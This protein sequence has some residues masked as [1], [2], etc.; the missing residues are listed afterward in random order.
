[1]RRL[2]LFC[3]I[4]LFTI[5]PTILAQGNILFNHITIDNGLSQSSVTCI[6]QDKLGF[7]W[8]GTQDGLNR[9][10]GYNFKVFKNIPKDSTSLAENFI[11]SLYED[12]SGTLYIETQSGIFHKYYQTTRLYIKI[13]GKNRNTRLTEFE[14]SH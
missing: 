5:T 7:M 3:A 1:M 13:L 2:I 10:D 4:A 8:F 9:Y 12:Q 14:K 11:Y 6:L